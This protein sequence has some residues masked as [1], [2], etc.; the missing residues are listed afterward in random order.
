MCRALCRALSIAPGI[1]S[2]CSWLS[3]AAGLCSDRAKMFL[4]WFYAVEFARTREGLTERGTLKINLNILLFGLV[5]AL[6]FPQCVGV[7]P[8]GDI[9]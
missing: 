7:A 6:N 4:A 2:I 8:I 5:P 1:V 3:A 9:Y